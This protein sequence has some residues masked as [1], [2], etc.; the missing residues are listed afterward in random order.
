MDTDLAELR[1]TFG[2]NLGRVI[3]PKLTPFP[4][5]AGITDNPPH[6]STDTGRP[7]QLP[8]M[9]DGRRTYPAMEELV[10]SAL[11]ELTP[12]ADGSFRVGAVIRGSAGFVPLGH[13]VANDVDNLW[14]IAISMQR[15]YAAALVLVTPWS[16]ECATYRGLP[17]TANAW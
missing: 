4:S 10:R 13:F 17:I 6:W 3:A 16:T 15:N 8:T 9:P 14:S 11:D 7:W 1:K 2:D 12:V 5:F